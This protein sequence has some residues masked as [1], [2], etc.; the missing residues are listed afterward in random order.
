M[1]RVLIITGTT[2]IDTDPNSTDLK[3]EE[4]FDLTLPS[5]Q[6]YAKK[7]GYDLLAMRSF[8]SDQSGR[9]PSRC[10]IGHLRVLRVFEMI[11][12]YDSVMW[13]DADSIVTNDNYKIEDFGLNDT[14]S[15]YASYDWEWKNSFST[16]NFIVNKNKNTQTL[17]DEFYRLSK[18]LTYGCEG[19]TL[20]RI[21]KNTNLSNLFNILE[22]KYLGSIPNIDICNEFNCWVN[23]SMIHWPWNKD[24]FLVHL[25][26]MTNE[27]RMKIARSY[28][29]EYL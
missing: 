20:N 1:R 18:Q 12:S 4:I 28:Y 6:R 13:I 27:N 15:F 2:D 26:G 22:H 19:E 3:M 21:H 9:I 14:Q 16:G 23:R 11:Q 7:H 25:T 10:A 5:K 24:S 8:G 17:I 29:K